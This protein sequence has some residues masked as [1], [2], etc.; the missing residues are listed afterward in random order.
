GDALDAAAETEVAE[1]TLLVPPAPAVPPTAKQPVSGRDIDV[2]PPTPATP[3]PGSTTTIINPPPPPPVVV[4][5][6]PEERSPLLSTQIRIALGGGYASFISREL[7]DVTQGGG[8]WDFRVILGAHSPV[9]I[10]LGYVGTANGIKNVMA[11]TI[12]PNAIL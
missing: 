12:D 10:E 2:T 8:T 4:Q 9:G 7:Q 5:Q 1:T 3:E 11:A 6:G